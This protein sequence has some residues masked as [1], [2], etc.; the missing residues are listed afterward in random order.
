ML[1]LG[2]GLR[3][4]FSPIPITSVP[5][6]GMMGVFFLI[7][8]HTTVNVVINY[9]ITWWLNDFLHVP[10]VTYMWSWGLWVVLFASL[11]TVQTLWWRSYSLLSSQKLHNLIFERVLFSR[12]SWFESQPVGRILNRFSKDLDMVDR[13]LPTSLEIFCVNAIRIISFFVVIAVVFPLFLVALVPIA[14]LFVMTGLYFRASSTQLRR[15]D[16]VVR[17]PVLAGVSAALNGIGVLRSFGVVDEF[18]RQLFEAADRSD[19]STFAFVS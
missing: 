16:G 9:Y 17:S 8:L 14:F 11:W 19:M 18:E 1:I 3:I 10:A 5:F 15:I 12:L 7:C 4:V 6:L 13:M 2:A